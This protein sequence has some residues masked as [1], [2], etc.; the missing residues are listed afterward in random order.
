MVFIFYEI[1]S[2]PFKISF[3][4]DTNDVWDH[5]VDALFLSD[6]VIAFNTA[7][8]HKGIPVSSFLLNI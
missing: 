7:Y 8:Y 5:L 1:I 4:I 6:I 3:D 2:I